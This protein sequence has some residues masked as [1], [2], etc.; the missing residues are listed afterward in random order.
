MKKNTAK[1]LFMIFAVYLLFSLQIV[2]FIEAHLVWIYGGKSELQ[3][4]TFNDYG[5]TVYYEIEVIHRVEEESNI[6]TMFFENDAL[7][8]S[9]EDGLFY[10]RKGVKVNLCETGNKSFTID[11]DGNLID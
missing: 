3:K 6:H 7:I 4:Y 2:F 1:T 9:K 5:V 11:K 8:V 10:L